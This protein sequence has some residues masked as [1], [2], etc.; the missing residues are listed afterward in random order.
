MSVEEDDTILP[1][2][3]IISTNTYRISRI[4]QI[5]PMSEHD[6]LTFDTSDTFA[7]LKELSYQIIC[8]SQ[9]N[10]T[11]QEQTTC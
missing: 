10:S 3:G 9:K 8:L 11:I 2:W 7:Q 4:Q 5:M 6:L 1:I